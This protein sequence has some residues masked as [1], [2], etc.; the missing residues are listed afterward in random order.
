ML[1]VIALNYTTSAENLFSMPCCYPL[2]IRACD[3]RKLMLQG[4]QPVRK[5]STFIQAQLNEVCMLT[6]NS[7]CKRI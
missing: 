5:H 3:I 6:S 2:M 7:N 1:M 4:V